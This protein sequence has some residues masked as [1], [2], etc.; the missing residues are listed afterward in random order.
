MNI[1]KQIPLRIDNNIYNKLK[2]VAKEED[3]M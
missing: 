3:R 1:K 2:E